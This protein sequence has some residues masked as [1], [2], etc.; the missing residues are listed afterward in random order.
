MAAMHYAGLGRF[1]RPNGRDPVV[2]PKPNGN[3]RRPSLS[4]LP[5]DHRGQRGRA[6]GLLRRLARFPQGLVT[7]DAASHSLRSPPLGY[8]AGLERLPAVPTTAGDPHSSKA[9]RALHRAALEANC[10]I[11]PVP[12]VI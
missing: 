9:A 8:S 2:R 7:S 11:D 5:P 10:R 6:T 3:A 1:A 4:L 12:F